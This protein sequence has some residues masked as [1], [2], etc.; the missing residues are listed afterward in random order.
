MGPV[1]FYTMTEGEETG[2]GTCLYI[3]HDRRGREGDGTCLYIYHDRRRRDGDGAC[4]YVHH[5]RREERGMGPVSIYTMTEGEETGDGT[6]LYIHHDR[7]NDE[8]LGL[9]SREPELIYSNLGNRT[10]NSTYGGPTAATTDQFC[11]AMLCARAS[12]SSDLDP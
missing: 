5:D 7:H 2:D 8:T 6:C 9:P 12:S 11:S 1:S 3:H 4:L 10:G